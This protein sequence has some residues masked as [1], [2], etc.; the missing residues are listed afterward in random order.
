MS[1][2]HLPGSCL[3]ALADESGGR[4]GDICHL[5]LAVVRCLLPWHGALQGGQ[6]GNGPQ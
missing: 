1:H 3:A 2:A 5:G 6:G 4:D